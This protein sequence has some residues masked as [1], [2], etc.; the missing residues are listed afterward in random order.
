[1]LGA[2]FKGKGKGKGKGG[3]GGKGGDK[4]GK[5]GKGGGNHIAQPLLRESASIAAR[6]DTG[7]AI[8]L[9]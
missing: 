1:M 5:G 2:M 4:G 3:K 6:R 9:C 8:V 7:K